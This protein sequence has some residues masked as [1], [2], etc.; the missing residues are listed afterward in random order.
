MA[1]PKKPAT[2]VS[3][4]PTQA[5]AEQST[6]K[7]TAVEKTAPKATTE[8]L[9]DGEAAVYKAV[10]TQEHGEERQQSALMRHI[11][12][13]YSKREWLMLGERVFSHP[14]YAFIVMAALGL[15]VFERYMLVM[16][17]L[18]LFF[19]LE[20][21][22]RFWLQ[23]EQGFRNRSEL[24]F[25][26]LDAVATISMFSAIFLP[27]QVLEQ[28][29]Y[30]RIARLF[31]GMYMLRMLRIF[32]FL[33]HDTLVFSLPFALALV[34][35]A[36]LAWA[37][38][39][40]G[41]YVGIVL[42]LETSCRAYS[43]YRVLPDGKRRRL[44]TAFIAPDLFAGVVLLG[45]FPAISS[46]WVLLRLARFLIML[47]P[48]G[49]IASA[50]SKVANLPEIRREGGM[51]AAMFLAFMIV[52]S[53]AMWYLYPH[54]DVNDDGSVNNTD[55]APFQVLLFV[56]RLMIDPGAAPPEAFT[57]W[58]AGLTVILVLS[59][60]FFFALV[61][62]LGSNVMQ[63]M[64][65]E[66]A[67]SPLSA[68]EHL[69]FVGWNE[70]SLPILNKLGQLSGRMRQSFPS[71]WVF[72]EEAAVGANRVGN[73]LSI[74]EVES[75]SRNLIE[76]FKLSGVR[77][78]I[79]F[80]QKQDEINTV[81]TADMHH[82][83]RELGTDG[84][85]VTDSALP[86][87]LSQVYEESLHMKLI[88]SA[89]IRARMLYQ[90]HHCSHMPELGI[91]MFD[92]VS[93]DVGL[94]ACSWDFDI[95]S[96]TAGAEIRCGDKQLGLEIWLSHCFAMGLN[97][98]GARRD[99]GSYILFSD[100][101]NHSVD[102]SFAH[103]VALGRDSLLWQGIMNKSF[104]LGS[105][106]HHNPLQAFT[107]PETWD[108]SMIFLGWHP[109]LPA[110]IEEMADRHHKLTCHVFSTCDEDD[111]TR[112]MRALRT[113][114]DKVNKLG[115]CTLKASVH[116][117]D[118]LDADALVAQL[119]GCKVIML[120]PEDQ[121]E[122][123]EDSLLELWLHE[124]GSMLNARKKKVKWWTPPKVMVL[125]RGGDNIESLEQAGAQY[126]LLDVR[127]GSPDAFHDVFMARQLLTQA[128]KHQ[129]PQ[130]TQHDA[131]TYEFMDA[132]LGD[133]VLVE[134]VAS[135]RLLGSE[136][137]SMEQVVGVQAA[138]N[139]G[140]EAVYRE[141]LRRGWILM[142]YLTADQNG[143]QAS[144]FSV[145]DDAF[146][147]DGYH[148]G[149]MQLLAGAP[150]VEM[151][152]PKQ[153]VSLLFCRR[154]VLNNDA[155]KVKAA[156]K[157]MKKAAVKKEVV[158][159]QAVKKTVEKA[160]VQ[161][162]KEVVA[163]VETA[164]KVVVAEPVVVKP[165]I[166]APETETKVAVTPAEQVTPP[167][168]SVAVVADAP[169]VV[170]E[171]EKVIVVA[172]KEDVE[173][174]KETVLATIKEPVAQEVVKVEEAVEGEVMSDS[175]W[176]KHADKRLIRVLQKQLEGSVDLL[177]SSSED[178]LIKLTEVLD[179]GI[180][181]EIEAKIMDALTDLQ[182]IDR[183]SQRMTNVKTCLSDWADQQPDASGKSLWEEEVSK[184][185]VME[186]ER[187]VLRGEL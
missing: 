5:A 4:S 114:A 15:C 3:A 79:V 50:A 2:S 51:L 132:M 126:E 120:Y 30:L 23:K 163:V 60:V 25:L 9:Y 56:F 117:W 33:T 130:E 154:G 29:I 49:N 36:G 149:N 113:V 187:M 168:S 166:K 141:A 91:K 43:L 184:R 32:R 38:P 99:D 135:S 47:N 1:E 178:G 76:R 156:K 93:G 101:I 22:L 124:V 144:A 48:L 159:K 145:L 160:A 44:E 118:G 13:G 150:V 80:M 73:W 142:A 14:R 170:A 155:S 100:L 63:Y 151:D 53:I 161:V 138:G 183:V 28:G 81:H 66:L 37:M 162:D 152:A 17:P 88:D 96:T 68:R 89:S 21:S 42:I 35:L 77:Q 172:A 108:L 181:P 10:E 158:A 86:P 39:S 105:P 69:M 58:L 57:P 54:L 121:P 16:V 157:P 40:L 26:L 98:L 139:M 52:G 97:L 110:M 87:R 85:I 185:Y 123:N 143:E 7:Q 12:G 107:W 180:S 131:F 55:Y 116:A 61:V 115:S 147:L 125:P 102:E 20:W 140:W 6:V 64:L 119:K 65:K 46:L 92:G 75:G 82:L 122:N 127:V 94:Q 19:T 41:I 59:G 133:A 165:S 95:I 112:Q 72:H 70:Q 45:V 171:V 18:A 34:G 177:H 8:P 11:S 78:L 167:A 111:L 104:H 175:V 136:L 67:N 128:R 173:P 164:V 169:K 182:N 153:T 62:S 24:A 84:L 148:S 103:V 146:P 174:E 71:V 27:V 179:M 186:E 134:D 106:I 83:A 137:E 129:H 176:P 31:R 109:G 74:R 90:M